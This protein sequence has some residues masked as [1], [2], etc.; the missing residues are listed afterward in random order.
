MDVWF[1]QGR[2][3]EN[4]WAFLTGGA[5]D[6]SGPRAFL[7]CPATVDLVG[8]PGIHC[9]RPRPQGGQLTAMALPASAPPMGSWGPGAM[10]SSV[11]S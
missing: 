10:A 4:D 6:R 5:H 9:I 2:G 1:C 8:Y 3:P 7:T 11:G